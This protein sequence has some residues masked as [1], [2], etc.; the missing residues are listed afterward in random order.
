MSA[1]L[2]L[3]CQRNGVNRDPRYPVRLVFRWGYLGT[4]LTVVD[5]AGEE[6]AVQAAGRGGGFR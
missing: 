6:Q 2:Q 1:T 3:P 5:H 4:V